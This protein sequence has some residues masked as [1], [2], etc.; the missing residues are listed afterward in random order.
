MNWIG[1]LASHEIIL[2]CSRNQQGSDRSVFQS[3]IRIFEWQYRMKQQVP[4]S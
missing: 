2:L 1:P 3:T 4:L